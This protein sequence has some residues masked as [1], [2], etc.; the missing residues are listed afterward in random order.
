MDENDVPKVYDPVPV[1]EQAGTL[2]PPNFERA[3]SEAK[4]YASSTT[5]IETIEQEKNRL[6]RKLHA[7]IQEGEMSMRSIREIL[8]R[9]EHRQKKAY[10]LLYTLQESETNKSRVMNLLRKHLE[11]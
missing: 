5:P 8:T 9:M 3:N 11:S 4:A 10:D 7:Q 1:K 6:V 2:Y